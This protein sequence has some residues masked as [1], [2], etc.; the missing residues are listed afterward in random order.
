MYDLYF[1]IYGIS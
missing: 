1:I